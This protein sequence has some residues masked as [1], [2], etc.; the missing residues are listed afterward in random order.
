MG[1]SAP[2]SVKRLVDLSD[3]EREVCQSSDYKEERTHSTPTPPCLKPILP[4]KLSPSDAEVPGLCPKGASLSL[5]LPVPGGV[6]TSSSA[7][8]A[9]E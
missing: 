1:A 5:S 3:R 9:S 2:D 7:A 6:L 8:L 4:T